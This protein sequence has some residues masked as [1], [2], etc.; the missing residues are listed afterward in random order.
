MKFTYKALTAVIIG[1]GFTYEGFLA[2]D[3]FE[4]KKSSLKTQSHLEQL[5]DSNRLY[6]RTVPY[7]RS[8]KPERLYKA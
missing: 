5:L 4:E 6:L 8:E 2:H 7:L 1:A 3:F